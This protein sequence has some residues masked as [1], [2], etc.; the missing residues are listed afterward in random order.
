MEVDH[1]ISVNAVSSLLQ[2]I[3]KQKFI[4]Y[5]PFDYG[6]HPFGYESRTNFGEF[7]RDIPHGSRPVMLEWS[8]KYYEDGRR[9][10]G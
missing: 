4:E 7:L 5:G 8:E 1:L 3:V 10:F 6:E 9:Y 2:G